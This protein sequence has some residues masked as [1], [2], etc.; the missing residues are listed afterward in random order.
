MTEREVGGVQEGSLE[1]L[2]GTKRRRR[3]PTDTAI[4]CVPDDRV[5]D[6][7]QM[8]PNLVSTSSRDGDL[9]KRRTLQVFGPG[10][11][12]E[13]RT[14]PPR[15]GR[16]LL[17]MYGVPTDGEVYPSTGLNDAPGEYLVALLDLAFL[18]LSCELGVG[19]VML[20]HHH[21]SRGS[22]VQSVDDPR[23][24]HASNA[25]QV[26]D[27]V[28]EGVDERAVRVS[29]RWVN[30]H[31]RRLVDHN[32][33]DVVVQDVDREGL[34]PWFG[35]DRRGNLDGDDVAHSDDGAR[36]SRLVTDPRSA[37]LDQALNLRPSTV[38]QARN[39]Y[40]VDTLVGLCVGHLYGDDLRGG[41]ID[42]HHTRR[43][44]P[45]RWSASA[46]ASGCGSRRSASRCSS[47]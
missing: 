19:A 43:H 12:G 47:G 45:A 18:E 21:D 32:Q 4:E 46:L 36:A 3:M 42:A 11:P 1:P 37:L 29:G 34:C 16:D 5:F 40:M 23:S 9:E 2:D 25:A 41:A 13:R 28:Q 35:W 38:T 22:A 26:A 20:G 8:D 44:A 15:P 33:V 14:C 30:D 7:A 17:P 27:V 6:G 39:Q 24:E 31:P 10:D